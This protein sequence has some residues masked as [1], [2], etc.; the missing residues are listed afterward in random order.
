MGGVLGHAARQTANRPLA[1]MQRCMSQ[2]PHRFSVPNLLLAAR[3]PYLHICHRWG[4]NLTPLS[5]P[6]MLAR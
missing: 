3:G 1:R 4:P 2:S 6:H 5:M